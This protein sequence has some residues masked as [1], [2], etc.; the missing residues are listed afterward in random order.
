MFSANTV[1]EWNFYTLVEKGLENEFEGVDFITAACL[2][3]TPSPK[4]GMNSCIVTSELF[5]NE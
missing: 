3:S 1:P 5:D 2:L 4:K